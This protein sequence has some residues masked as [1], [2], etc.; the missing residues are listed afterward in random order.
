[1]AN[2]LVTGY[3]GFVGSH[4][5]EELYYTGHDVTLLDHLSN[6]YQS[7]LS[8][9][10]NKNTLYIS[11]VEQIKSTIFKKFDIIF[12]LATP[13]RSSSLIDPFQNIATICKGM[14]SVLELAKKDDTK[15]VFTGNF[16]IYGYSP[17]YAIKCMIEYTRKI[18]GKSNFLH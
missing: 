12:H 10:K 4:F 13:P 6:D 14:V 18:Q 17:E 7:Y 9:L 11:N 8:H 2:F 5:T 1:M 3:L 16:G 15:V